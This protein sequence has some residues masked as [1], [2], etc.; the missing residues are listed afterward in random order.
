MR[1]DSL[2]AC[3]NSLI[4]S[5]E[6]GMNVI[7]L[8][9]ASTS[10]HSFYMFKNVSVVPRVNIDDRRTSDQRHSNARRK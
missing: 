1:C 2:G 5:R 10:A 4:N 9:C 6:L 7:H 8:L 3:Q